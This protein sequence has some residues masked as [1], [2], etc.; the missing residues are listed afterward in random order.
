[1]EALQKS[2]SCRVFMDHLRGLIKEPP[3]LVLFFVSTILLIISSFCPKY[4]YTFLAMFLYSIFGIVWRH[5]IKDIRG[6]LKEAYPNNFSKNNFWLTSAYQFIN[7]MAVCALILVI[8][9][10]CL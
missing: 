3:Y 2:D 10:Y 9:R 8:V 6:R 4:F 1:M 7:L 5:A